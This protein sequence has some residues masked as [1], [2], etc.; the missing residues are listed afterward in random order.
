MYVSD[1]VRAN[2]RAATTDA[3]GE[4]NIGTGASVS[5]RELAE[6]V[7]NVTD[8]GSEIVHGDR[9]SGDIQES[10][11]DRAKA[12]RDLGFEPEVD[13]SDGLASLTNESE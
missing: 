13:L 10:R 3:T 6:T 11:A 12:Q 7:V 8:S 2:L 1:V 4:A 9:R 5:I